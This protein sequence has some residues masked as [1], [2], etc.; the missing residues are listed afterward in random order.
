MVSTATV[1]TADKVA[2]LELSKLEQRL[3][4][5]KMEI[6]APKTPANSG[7][8]QVKK[9]PVAA[10]PGPRGKTVTFAD[11]MIAV[12]APQ[13]PQRGTKRGASSEVLEML[14]GMMKVSPEVQNAKNSTRSVARAANAPVPA[15]RP[16]RLELEIPWI[17]YS[18]HE[19]PWAKNFDV[20]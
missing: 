9:T 2:Q 12:A 16:S 20:E 11:D 15:P 19:E 7:S 4:A 13:K 18:R 5:L 1:P 6:S 8:V 3:Q 17:S 14:G 10:G